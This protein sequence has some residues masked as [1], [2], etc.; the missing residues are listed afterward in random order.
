MQKNNDILFL[1]ACMSN[2]GS[3]IQCLPKEICL[4]ILQLKHPFLIT[5]EEFQKS[6]AS[7]FKLLCTT[8]EYLNKIDLSPLPSLL[9]DTSSLLVL[10]E[11]PS[12]LKEV[13]EA[14]VVE[15][16]H[17]QLPKEEERETCLMM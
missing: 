6:L 5:F 1:S 4:Y 16:T 7:P 15:S 13:D 11:V 2:S 3:S 8:K 9:L 10:A 17:S 14:G 12:L